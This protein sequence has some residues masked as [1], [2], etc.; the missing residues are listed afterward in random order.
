MARAKRLREIDLNLLPVL[1]S[2]LETNS[3]ARTAAALSMTP[4]AVSHALRRLRTTLGDELFVRTRAGLAPTRRAAS[5]ADDLGVGLTT[6][7]RALGETKFDPRT[8]TTTFRVAT[9]DF[10]ARAIASGLIG[11]LDTQAPGVQVIIR[12]L[13]ARPE[14]ALSSGEVDVVI[15]PFRGASTGLYRKKLFDEQTA[16]LARNGHPRVK[17]GKLAFDDYVASGHVLVAPHGRTGSRIDHLLAEQ[18]LARRIALLIPSLLLGPHVVAE[19]SLLLSAGRRLL[20]SFVGQ[21]PVQIVPLPLE[22]PAVDVDMIWH[23][24]LHDDPAFGWFRRQLATL[25]DRV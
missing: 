23:A 21:L 12:P 18:G 9:T 16:V 11:V 22:L 6:I 19:T 8:A 5:L 2:L 7:E 4:S 14:E 13:P 20:Q 1:R 25:H 17:R 3:A 24:R 10:G 15:A